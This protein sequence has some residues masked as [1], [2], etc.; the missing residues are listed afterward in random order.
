MGETGNTCNILIGNPEGKRPLKR[1]RIILELILGTRGGE[2]C[3]G[4]IWLSIGTSGE[5]L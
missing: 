1:L 2:L 4:F 3:T 5:L